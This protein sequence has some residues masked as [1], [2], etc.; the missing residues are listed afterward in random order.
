MQYDYPYGGEVVERVMPT[1]ARTLCM[2]MGA[3]V[4]GVACSWESNNTC[5]IVL[6][7]NGY[8]PVDVF[9]RHEI[10]HCNGWPANHPRDG[11]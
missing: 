6:P 9:R 3:D 4:L 11:R 1:E 5:Y 7:N 2:S 10:A 8:A